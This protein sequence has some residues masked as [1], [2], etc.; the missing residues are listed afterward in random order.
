[1]RHGQR[2]VGGLI[3]AVVV[4]GC[5]GG[6]DVALPEPT[7]ASSSAPAVGTASPAPLTFTPTA[8]P[9]TL[10][11]HNAQIV[12][13][14]AAATVVEAIAIDA[15]GDILA[16]GSD[17][18]VT[19]AHLAARTILLDLEGQTMVPGFVDPH[20]HVMQ[21]PAPDI[22]EMLAQ[23]GTLIVQ[24]TTTA[25]TPSVEPDELA[26]FRQIDADGQLVVRTQLYLLYNS[27]CGERLSD[28]FH[29]SEAFTHDPDT[30]LTVAGVKV[31]GD[32]GACAAPALGF[33][34]LD[35][36]PQS[37]KDRGWTGRGNLYITPEELADVVVDVEAAGGQMVV[38]AIGDEA[39]RTALAG[40]Q[41]AHDEV[42][43]FTQRHRLDHNSMVSQ[44]SPDEIAIYG[45]VGLR[46]IV[47][48]MPW[49]NACADGTADVW[50]S[51]WPA[52]VVANLENRSLIA[53]ANPGIVLAWHGDQPSIQGGPLQQMHTVVT[54][55]AVESPDGEI[56]APPEWASFPTTDVLGAL[57]MTT[58]DAAAAM[59][60]DERVGSLEVGKVADLLVLASDILDPDPRVALARNRPLLTI[61]GGKAAF[62]TGPIC[63]LIRPIEPVVP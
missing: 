21:N 34:Y 3:A 1:M 20:T 50:N 22:D 17:A 32:G 23:V 51:I 30:L 26:A 62:C 61:I 9:A 40:Y 18:D 59:D 4:A 8:E 25:G 24:G 39:M 58:I 10:I 63:E 49:T 36:T 19:A 44:L 35:S 47:Q 56:C 11:F 57:R 16:V 55:E 43:D 37:L 27:V 33:D 29:L 54:R 12:T 28:D 60:I 13:M 38:H 2:R 53:E 5:S 15:D 46:P 31:F 41:L 48:L 42:G 52:E 6:G 7:T 14:D 45:R